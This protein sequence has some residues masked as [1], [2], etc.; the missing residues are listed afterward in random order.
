MAHRLPMRLLAL[1]LACTSPFAVEARGGDPSR[2]THPLGDVTDLA[3]TVEDGFA[4]VEPGPHAYTV[5]VTNV[6][7]NPAVGATL[8]CVFQSPLTAC[9]W[10][11]TPTG[12][13]CAG[14][15]SGNIADILDLDAG[16]QAVYHVSCILPDMVYGLV[17]VTATITADKTNPDTNTLNDTDTDTTEVVDIVF[18]D[19]FETGDL[20]GWSFALP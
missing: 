13:T 17:A 10:T 5:T 6:G 19:G 14:A 9:Q 1:A 20:D 2:P 18:V 16:G 11:C 12:A 15:G 4:F 7:T 8:S 3:V